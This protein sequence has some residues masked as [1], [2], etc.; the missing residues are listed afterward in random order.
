M[1]AQAQWLP[2][3][4]RG[5]VDRKGTE[6]CWADTSGTQQLQHEP[7]PLLMAVFT[8]GYFTLLLS[9][10]MQSNFLLLISFQFGSAIQTFIPV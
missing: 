7:A 1:V 6:L 8:L 9:S 10:K 5:H 2:A 3:L 4:L